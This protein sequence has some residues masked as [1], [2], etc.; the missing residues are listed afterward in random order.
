VPSGHG[1]R[2]EAQG[3]ADR[4]E[5]ELWSLRMETGAAAPTTG[6]CL[7]G[8][9]GWLEIKFN[10]RKTRAS[11][12]LDTIS[13]RWNIRR[14]GSWRRLKCRS[15]RKGRYT[16]LVTLIGLTEK[17]ERSCLKNGCIRMKTARDMKG[18]L[19]E[20]S[21]K[22]PKS[23]TAMNASQYPNY[24]YLTS[25]SN[26]NG[27]SSMV[28]AMTGLRSRLQATSATG[29]G[30]QCA[31]ALSTIRN[32]AGS[33]PVFTKILPHDCARLPK[34]SG[35]NGRVPTAAVPYGYRNRPRLR[36]ERSRDRRHSND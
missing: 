25:S 27:C 29:T 23:K 34:G 10:G 36:Q 31:K 6:Q 4:A 24:V 17:P 21:R 20:R 7:S 5:A 13:P 19:S 28:S 11:L 3:D 15:C 14:S 12:P 9:L 8:G 35:R 30:L 26:Q 33:V 1:K 2:E 22:M 16:P 18:R 32:G